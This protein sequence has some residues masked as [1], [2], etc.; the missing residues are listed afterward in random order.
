MSSVPTIT[1]NSMERAIFF[2]VS[3]ALG[4]GGSPSGVSML[5]VVVSRAA[6]TE[7]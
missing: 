2:S 1:V 3:S 4:G 5:E 6:A 7:Q